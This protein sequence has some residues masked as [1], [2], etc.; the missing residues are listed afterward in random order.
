MREEGV[1]EEGGIDWS[2]GKPGVILD[3]CF[4]G[5]ALRGID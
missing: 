4:A 1:M 3:E 5:A 2:E